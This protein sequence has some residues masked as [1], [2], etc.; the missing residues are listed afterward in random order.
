MLR[1]IVIL[2]NN[3]SGRNHFIY[4]FNEWTLYFGTI[5]LIL[6]SLLPFIFKINCASDKNCANV[7]LM[8]I[9]NKYSIKLPKIPIIYFAFR[10]KE[11]KMNLRYKIKYQNKTLI[12]IYEFCKPTSK[13]FITIIFI[14]KSF[15]F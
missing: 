2:N 9:Y 15:K 5:K 6:K 3:Y 12:K 10:K 8:S 14:F 11:L 7:L 13:I 1:S 4:I